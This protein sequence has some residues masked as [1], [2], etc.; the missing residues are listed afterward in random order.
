M[1][2]GHIEVLSRIEKYSALR[3][4]SSLL[5]KSLALCVREN[6]WQQ[7]V[8]I[9]KTPVAVDALLQFMTYLYPARLKRSER[10]RAVYRAQKLEEAGHE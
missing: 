1:N 10:Q 5:K 8:Q 3:L 4:Q 7:S 9:R 6:K 2:T